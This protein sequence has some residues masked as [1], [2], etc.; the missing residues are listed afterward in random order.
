MPLATNAA[1][2][3]T[4]A[5]PRLDLRA[6]IGAVGSDIGGRVARIENVVELPAVVHARVADRIAAH[7]LVLAIDVHVVLVAEVRASV[8]LR[9]AS[10][11]V[12]LSL[13]RGFPRG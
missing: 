12:L 2:K 1:L 3:S 6:A 5:K 8:L 10:F 11:P 13:L 7:Q 9:P 4:F